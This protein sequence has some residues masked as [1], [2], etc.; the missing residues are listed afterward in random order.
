MNRINI[1]PIPFHPN[2]T[3]VH[4]QKELSNTSQSNFAQILDQFKAIEPLKIS[5]HATERMQQRD[6]SI[7]DQ[8]WDIITDKVLEAK[9]KGVKQPLV[10]LDQATLIVSATNHTV[11]T[12]LDR[13]ETK[14]Q[15]FTNI[16]G[17][18]VL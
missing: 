4:K 1:N 12:A 18:I 15:L 13:Q 10:I 7:S 8:E 16:D 17:T 14:E 9:Q 11:I 5:K 3:K 6:I 2:I